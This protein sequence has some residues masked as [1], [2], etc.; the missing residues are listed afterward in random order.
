MSGAKIPALDEAMRKHIVR[1]DCSRLVHHIWVMKMKAGK[2]V[3]S[4]MPRRMRHTSSPVKLVH[5]AVATVTMDQ[6]VKLNM[7]QYLTIDGVRRTGM[8]YDA[9]FFLKLENAKGDLPG[10]T[11][12]AY[13]ESG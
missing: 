11:M 1:K 5:A 10:K 8:Y 13:E 12:S 4:K 7:T 6:A 2:M 3:A 9:T